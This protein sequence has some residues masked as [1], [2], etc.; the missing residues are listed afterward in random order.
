MGARAHLPSRERRR[1]ARQTLH[2]A[3]LL[4]GPDQQRRVPSGRG[5]AL[6]RARQA[7]HLTVAGDVLAVEDHAADLAAADAA[8]AAAVR[9]RGRSCASSA[10]APRRARRRARPRGGRR[11]AGPRLRRSRCRRGARGAT[12]GAQQPARRRPAGPQGA[13]LPE[14]ERVAA[15]ARR[16]AQARGGRGARP[17]SE[18]SEYRRWRRTVTAPSCTSAPASR[19]RRSGA[20]RAAPAPA[21]GVRPASS[22]RGRRCCAWNSTS[23]AGP[24][25]GRR[26][27]SG[28][29]PAAAVGELVERERAGDRAAVV[30]QRRPAAGASQPSARVGAEVGLRRGLRARA[31]RRRCGRPRAAERAA[32]FGQQRA[33]R[34]FGLVV[35]ALADRRRSGPARARRSGS[36][37]ARPGCRRRSRCPC[38]CPGRPDSAARTGRSRRARCRRRARRRTPASRRR[39]SSARRGR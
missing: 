10:S 9:P 28:D 32:A 33:D 11:P 2:R 23:I 39:R 27:L 24:R 18:T 5:G 29:P 25:D 26:R 37:R 38:R 6:Q 22:A 1:G 19:G 20:R 16:E 30:V 8:R 15:D 17:G 4:V 12:I 36:R 3:A 34:R 31:R 35:V 14:R 13:P 7:Q 21:A